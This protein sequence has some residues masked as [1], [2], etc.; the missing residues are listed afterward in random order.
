MAD[1]DKKHAFMSIQLKGNDDDTIPE[2][3]QKVKDSFNIDGIDVKQ[4]GLQP[5]PT[6]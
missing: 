3:L 1:A 6:N 4:A 5:W 2:Q